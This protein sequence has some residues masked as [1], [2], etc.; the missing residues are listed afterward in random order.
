MPVRVKICGLTEP[1]DL[2]ALAPLG[3]DAI[4]LNFCAGSPRRLTP[5]RAEVLLA[6]RP[7]GVLAVGVF[8]DA[9]AAHVAELA[10]RLA[11]E[12]VQLHGDEP[13]EHARWLHA[14]D[15]RVIK[16]FRLGA[17]EHLAAMEAWLQH[18]ARL[19][20]LPE[21]VLLDAAV[22]GLQGGTGRTL[23][24]EL[25]D[26]LAARLPRWDALLPAWRQLTWVLAG[27]L[28][29]ANVAERLARCPLPIAMVDTASGVESAP[30]RKDPARVAAFVAAARS[31]G[32]A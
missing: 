32:P 9:P 29:P 27:G 3:V 30:G 23:P 8:A 19:D 6:A 4:G 21:A 26:L 22:P 24:D 31:H 5:E 18:A 12:A 17:P 20:A 10:E 11:L 1:D 13:P 14:A 7:H 15:L 28:N 25:L 16:A 2:G